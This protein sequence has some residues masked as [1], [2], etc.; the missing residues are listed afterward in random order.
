MPSINGL[1]LIPDITGGGKD[2]KSDL[3]PKDLKEIA[4]YVTNTDANPVK[5]SFASD[6]GSDRIWKRVISD[7]YRDKPSPKTSEVGEKPNKKSEPSLAS[8]FKSVKKKESQDPNTG[9]DRRIKKIAVTPMDLLRADSLNDVIPLGFLMIHSDLEKLSK[10]TEG[11]GSSAAGLTA[12]GLLAASV[13]AMSGS[14]NMDPAMAAII[15]DPAIQAKLKE[16]PEVFEIIKTSTMTYISAF[17][18]NVLKQFGVMELPKGGKDPISILSGTLGAL[19]G[20]VGSAVG[21]AL[22]GIVTQVEAAIV[23]TGD[24]IKQGSAIVQEDPDIKEIH[25]QGMKTYLSAYYASILKQFGIATMP[26]VTGNG[27]ID[28]L[29]G[30]LSVVGA[31][32]GEAGTAV[33][34]AF[35]GIT[36]QVASAVSSVGAVID[37]QKEIWEEEDI[38]EIH[39]TGTKQYL[40]AYYASILKQFGIATLPESTG[41]KALDFINGVLSVVGAAGGALGQ[42]VGAGSAAAASQVNQVDAMSKS[43]EAAQVE[44]NERDDVQEIHLE[45]TKA[46]LSAFYAYVLSQMGVSDLDADIDFANKPLSSLSKFLSG[47][48]KS[49]GTASGNAYAAK[50]S[51]KIMTDALRNLVGGDDLKS[52]TEI[53]SIRRTYTRQIL[54]AYY[55]N[56]LHDMGYDEVNDSEDTSFLGAL[57]GWITKAKTSSGEVK[58]ASN[59]LSAIEH[60]LDA[61]DLK[62]DPD[63]LSIRK[64]NTEA[65]LSA[66]YAKVLSKM[67]LKAEDVNEKAGLG[68]FGAFKK[69]L[70]GE[71]G[72]SVDAS[73]FEKKLLSMTDMEDLKSNADILAL[74]KDNSKLLLDAYYAKL[75]SGL[76]V[77]EGDVNP[78]G[79]GLLGKFKKLLTGSSSYSVDI[80]SMEKI[81]RESLDIRKITGDAEL[82]SLKRKHAST[83]LDTYAAKV[84]AGLQNSS[85]Q[86]TVISTSYFKDLFDLNRNEKASITTAKVTYYKNMVSRYTTFLSKK[87]EEDSVWQESAE[88][89]QKSLGEAFHSANINVNTELKLSSEDKAGI[90]R[91]Q[92]TL[93]S[94]IK[95]TI[96]EEVQVLRSIM[97]LVSSISGKMS[98]MSN[99]TPVYMPIVT[100]NEPELQLAQ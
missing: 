86:D 16:D 65:A 8:A 67:G 52:D 53:D 9:G 81:L 77:S 91:I 24:T 4:V 22:G 72:F 48:T 35:G 40:S 3:Y 46:Y 23:M 5:V 73:A 18:S 19:T 37:A 56:V 50:E 45:G 89:V 93:S 11:T 98:T 2:N 26:V 83:L 41:N 75:L 92:E 44:L 20:G 66:Y 10:G 63:I 58:G 12:A 13:G 55:A 99:T 100:N 21:A 62:S 32:L 7:T 30:T 70:T 47:I 97:N 42:A 34:A 28:F 68:I 49:F 78:S 96:S 80:S 88:A 84:D 25:R 33:G 1:T 60:L 94:S 74:R 39:R 17:Y 29:N 71:S 14:F 76:G 43:I 15:Q 87:L 61:S 36:T 64:E 54:S 85:V 95:D 31:L 38:K 27:A 57:K 90:S 6:Q 79:S 69:L 51:L 82:D 59:I